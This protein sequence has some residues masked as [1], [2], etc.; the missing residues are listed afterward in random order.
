ML[1]SIITF[2]LVH[3]LALLVASGMLPGLLAEG[4][5]ATLRVHRTGDATAAESVPVLVDT[6]SPEPGPLLHK[7]SESS[8]VGAWVLIAKYVSLPAN[9][10]RHSGRAPHA[11]HAANPGGAALLEITF[12]G[13]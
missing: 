13:R 11:L 9:V 3:G 8:V 6:V 7:P 12:D 5:T 2:V 4:C 10:R 1:R